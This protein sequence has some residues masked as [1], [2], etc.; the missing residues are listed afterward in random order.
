[1]NKLILHHRYVNGVAFD[2]S[3][4]FNHGQTSNVQVA[5][6]PYEGLRFR[7]ESQMLVKASDTFRDMHQVRLVTS[8]LVPSSSALS[9]VLHIDVNGLVYLDIDSIGNWMFVAH[10][11]GSQTVY[12]RS[13]D[14]NNDY[15]INLDSWNEFDF[16][17]NGTGHLQVFLNGNLVGESFQAPPVG[18]VGLAGVNLHGWADGAYVRELRLYKLDVSDLGKCMFDFSSV[19]WDTLRPLLDSLKSEGATA[20]S[21]LDNLH[22]ILR[23]MSD[24]GR[25]ITNQGPLAMN[26]MQGAGAELIHSVISADKNRLSSAISQIEKL[27]PILP[28]QQQQTNA[29]NLTAVLNNLP[30]TLQNG[31]NLLKILR[32][33]GAKG[34]S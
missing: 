7:Q 25:Q 11:H 13:L 21:L 30:P 12:I 32:A 5:S 29:Q 3:N 19:D 1:M 15:A 14:N 2:I 33:L 34:F 24:M 18:S 10:D 16:Q 26:T 6:S 23:T 4:N 28:Q 27:P 31:D 20:E 8:V 17:N 22:D 9:S